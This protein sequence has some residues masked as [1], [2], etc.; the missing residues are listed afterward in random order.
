MNRKPKNNPAP[1]VTISLADI[2]DFKQF[3]A[4]RGLQTRLHDRSIL[5]TDTHVFYDGHW[6]AIMYNRNEKRYTID[7]R[8]KPLVD[9]FLLTR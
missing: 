6:M 5:V 4:N 1:K 3:I 2:F 7:R 9:E 8:M